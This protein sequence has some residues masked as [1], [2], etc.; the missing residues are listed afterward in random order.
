MGEGWLTEGKDGAAALGDDAQCTVVRSPGRVP[1]A[2]CEDTGGTGDHGALDAGLESID[3][4][5]EVIITVG[6]HFSGWFGAGSCGGRPGCRSGKRLL[7]SG[8][9]LGKLLRLGWRLTVELSASFQDVQWTA[10]NWHVRLS[11][12]LH[13]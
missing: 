9:G 6:R 13:T 7:E 2:G 8:C 1:D 11:Q 4:V 3:R 5:V 12:Q 10:S